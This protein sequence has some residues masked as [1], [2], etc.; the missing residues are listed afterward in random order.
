MTIESLTRREKDVL[1]LLVQGKLNKEIGRILDMAERTV[2]GH[3]HAIFEKFGVNSVPALVYET[4]HYFAATAPLE[5]VLVRV[6]Q[7]MAFYERL[8]ERQDI[9]GL[10]LIA[11][12]VRNQKAFI[13][14][15]TP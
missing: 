10:D 2:K 5:R 13:E 8:Q 15:N 11:E 1:E 12:I 7:G 9:Q 14:L 6:V 4:W 3:R